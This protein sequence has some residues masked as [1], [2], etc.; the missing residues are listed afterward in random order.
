MEACE[1]TRCLVALAW[2]TMAV[3]NQPQ[4]TVCL[5]P[6]HTWLTHTSARRATRVG[7]SR[8]P[9]TPFPSWPSTPRPQQN[10]EPLHAGETRQRCETVRHDL[11]AGS[12][13]RRRLRA[14]Q[15]H[16]THL[17]ARATACCPEHAMAV[18]PHVT[19]RPSPRYSDPCTVARFTRLRRRGGFCLRGVLAFAAERGVRTGDGGARLGVGAATRG[20][21][22][23]CE[24]RGD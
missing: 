15:L 7:L 22:R 3:R 20:D 8:S 16:T 23:A 18:M 14:C 1:H 11:W 2:A 17:G 9:C 24:G 13:H 21:L 4:R 19:P 5:S 10:T 12:L 6:Q